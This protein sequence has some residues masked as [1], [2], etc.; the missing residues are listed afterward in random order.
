[1]F[2]R[3]D[4]CSPLNVSRRCLVSQ[5]LPLRRVFC[6]LQ[7]IMETVKEAV[8]LNDGGTTVS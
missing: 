2:D 7:K 3:V 4:E 6:R 5:R 8:G 1:M